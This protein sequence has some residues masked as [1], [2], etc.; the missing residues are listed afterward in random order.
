MEKKFQQVICLLAILGLMVPTAAQATNG[1]YLHGTGA[2]AKGMG[3]ASIGYAQDAFSGA[4]NPATLAFVEPQIDYDFDVMHPVR[5]ATIRNNGMG[6]PTGEHSGDGQAFNVGPEIAMVKKINDNTV[7]GFSMAGSG[8][9]VK[10]NG[11]LFGTSNA[12]SNIAQVQFNFSWAKKISDDSAIGISPYFAYQRFAV[13]GLENFKGLSSD[14]AHVTNNGFDS[15]TGFGVRLGG[16]KEL[17]PVTSVGLYYQTRT[18]MSRFEKY[19]GI[20]AEHGKFDLPENYGVGFAFKT[21]PKTN[22]AFDIVRI[23][24]GDLGSL[25]RGESAGLM[26]SDDGPGFGWKSQTVY[27]LGVEYA[28][29]ERLT[30]RA[31]CD[32]AKSP[33]LPEQTLFNTLAPSVSEYHLTLGATWKTSPR[34]E[35]TLGYM[36]VISN[37]VAG[38]GASSFADVE[39]GGD[40]LCFGISNK[41]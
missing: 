10:Y 14:P 36:H 5:T 7:W 33:I 27:K 30:L 13:K 40:T 18:S 41:I 2:K 22:M 4:S 26:G 16:F 23:N 8:M 24:Y 21:S 28:A 31:G 11:P 35:F 25:S 9:G 15:S 17:N 29:S 32:Y 3:G 20:I 39:L 19:S 1:L 37:K 38:S 12:Y 34:S 6:V